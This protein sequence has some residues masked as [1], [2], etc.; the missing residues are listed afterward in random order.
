MFPPFDCEPA[1]RN[2]AVQHSYFA[3]RFIFI[4]EML[5]IGAK[6]KFYRVGTFFA[7]GGN[8]F[9]I[10]RA[11]ILLAD[12]DAGI[13]ETLG[14]VLESEH[15]EV[16]YAKTGREAAAKF[17]ADLPDLVLLDLN[18][19]DRDGWDAFNL[20]NRTHP[21]VPVIV[22]TARPQQHEH[23]ARLGI[24]A[25]MEKPLNLPL[26]L[27]I[28]ADLLAESQSER[29][30]RLIDP[31]FRTTYISQPDEDFKKELGL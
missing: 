11:K 6:R 29:M 24:D 26:L 28:I 18:M 16:V 2:F 3:G 17:I 7:K 8:D 25:L 15:Y 4:M 19:P 12:D 14:R 13:R 30:K 21:S 5:K 23:A 20:M 27:V 22:I 31:V 1:P 10:M 9:S